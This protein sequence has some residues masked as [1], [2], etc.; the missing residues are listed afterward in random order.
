MSD[1]KPRAKLQQMTPILCVSDFAASLSYYTEK[2]GFCKAWAWG[3]PESFGCVT[4]NDVEIF[5]A[6]N[7]QGK[8]GMW[9]S[10]FVSDVNALHEELKANGANVVRELRDEPW[11]TR[12]FHVQ[13]P[14]GHTFRFG[15]SG[16]E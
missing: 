3:T 8:P 5:L 2:L 7:G 16:P 13:D 15:Q 11:G 10:I 9:A 12:E 1:P 6:L 4:R 14:D